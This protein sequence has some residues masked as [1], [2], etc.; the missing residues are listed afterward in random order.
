MRPISLCLCLL[1]MM[2]ILFSAGIQDYLYEGEEQTGTEPFY[3]LSANYELIYIDGAAALLVKNGEIVTNQG[4]IEAA[5]YQYSVEQHY[6]SQSQID[7]LTELLDL[8]H[9]SREDG[10]MW[11]GIE[12]EECRMGIFLH[13]F[14]CT[15]E[16][17]PTNFEEAK[18]NDCYL[19]ASVLCDEYGDY[20]GCSDPVMIMPIVQDFSISS[21]QLTAIDEKTR[22]D[23]ANISEANIYDVFMEI[24]ENIGK[25]RGYEQKLEE[26]KFRVPY[27]QGG[28]ECNDCYGMCPPII[29]EGQY[30]EDAEELVD[31]MLPELEYIGNYEGIAQGIY[32]STVQRTEFKQVN[33]QKAYYFSI[34]EPEEERAEQ[35][36]NESDELLGYVS[37]SEV[38]SSAERARQI[39][40]SIEQDLNDSEFGTMDANLD[41]LEAKLNVLEEKVSSSWEI[42]NATV[43]AKEEADAVFFML[44]TKD[45]SEEQQ[46]E[47]NQL[48]AE[49]RTQDRGFV[50]GLS[51]EKY[52]QI[53]ESYNEL[54][55]K[56]TALLNSV[57]QAEQVVDTF[58]GAGTKTNEGIID[59]A[60]TMT[61]LEREEK[62]EVS[63]YAPLLVSSLA[64][65]SV[66]SLA[67]FVFLFAFA[68][69]S[70]FFRNKI[71]L[72]VGILLIGCSVLFAGVISGSIYYVLESSSTDASFGDFQEHVLS[73][74]HVS[75]MVETEG[76]H[77]SASNKMMECAE[78]LADSFVG[79]EVIVYQKT[80]S[81]CIVG[82]SGVTLAE[83]YNSIEEP[84]IAFQYSTVDE[85]PQFMTGFV[86]KGTFIG[87][88]EYFS[89]CQVA[90]AFLPTGDFAAA[91]GESLPETNETG[92][93]ETE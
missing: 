21:N 71:I 47:L 59:L 28:D 70:N 88:E 43:E 56:A 86:Y 82:E 48:E 66:S 16:S 8:Y 6:P 93:N 60:S 7:E 23:L 52:A 92:S 4:E 49:K 34:Y 25:M 33:E 3:A 57:E 19:T 50:D 39:M 41:E 62:E 14:P 2:G 90:Q 12:E 68:T 37:D 67:I 38:I 80:N 89:E 24:K 69:F 55:S 20:L 75:I 46:A 10:N 77:T 64:F 54:N 5:L 36:L 29:I 42:Y 30:L 31:E 26:T 9:A 63:Q 74:P 58:K 17:I 85:S 51:P 45:I 84:I 18:A 11:E 35:L 78:E 13:A 79:K 87:D 61:P 32:D 83:C 40:E 76:V 27:T 73:S 1:F 53:T 44:D 81:E 72:F 15:N 22:A 65:F 91:P